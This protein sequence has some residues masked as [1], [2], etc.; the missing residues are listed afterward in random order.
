MKANYRPLNNYELGLQDGLKEGFHFGINLATIAFNK[1]CG[2]GKKRIARAE[3]VCQQ[4][5][6][7][8]VDVKDATW[9]KK[10]IKEALGKIK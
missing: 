3:K 7:E 1:S 5:L 2:I 10:K 4:L 8:I 6:N 9:T